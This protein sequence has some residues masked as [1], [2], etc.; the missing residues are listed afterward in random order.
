VTRT[1]WQPQPEPEC[2]SRVTVTVT[3]IKFSPS[4]C[5]C[6]AAG[7]LKPEVKARPGGPGGWAGPGRRLG[8]GGGNARPGRGFS[9]HWHVKPAAAD[10]TSRVK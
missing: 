10:V 5:Q 8:L 6:P 9:N 1:H 4:Q 2:R 3:V 7:N